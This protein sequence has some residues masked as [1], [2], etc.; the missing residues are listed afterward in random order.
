MCLQ[1]LRLVFQTYIQSDLMDDFYKLT[2]EEIKREMKAK[3]VL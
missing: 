3:Y 1:S 2:V